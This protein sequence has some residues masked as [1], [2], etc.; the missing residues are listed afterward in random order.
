MPLEWWQ[1]VVLGVVEGV[2]EYLP[3]SSTGH[4]ILTS[5]LLGLDRP[6]RA[7]ALAAFEVVVQGGAILAVL[8]LYWRRVLQMGAGL[9]G[10]DP[11]GRRL[12]V[13]L[14]VGFLPAAVLGPLLD[15][16][17]ERHLFAAGPVLAALVVGGVWMIWLDRR[18][19]PE[20]GAPLEALGWRQALSIGLFQ[21][22][23]LWPGTSRSMMAI[24]GGTILGLRASDAAEFS[25]LLGLPTL[26]GACAFKLVKNLLAAERTGTPNLFEQLGAAPVAI[27]I[28]V[29]ALSAAFAVRWLVAFLKR[30]GLAPFGWYRI[31]LALLFGALLLSGVVELPGEPA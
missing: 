19:A 17:I 2:T 12:L 6:D 30:H 11:G 4:L 21:C 27:G 9:I 26:G 8:G 20:V 10:H 7:G 18:R 22:A 28:V 15:D 23:A 1:A 24:A 3:V 25:F 31:A 13:N 29:A 16:P 14:A 5:S